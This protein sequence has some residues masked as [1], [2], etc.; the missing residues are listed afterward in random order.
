TVS[1]VGPDVTDLRPGDHVAYA[2]NAGAYGEYAVV[3]AWKLVKL[4]AGMDAKQGA[5]V[6]LEGMTAQYLAY[7]T[8]P[9]K[10]GQTALVHAGGGG[11]GLL[12]TQIARNIGATVIT[13]VGND[14]KAEL[15]RAAGAHHVIVYSR[16]DFDKEVR[17]ITGGKGVEVVYDSVGVNTFD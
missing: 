8:F 4:R 17:N 9:L 11:V 13:T 3:T 5:A 16:Q 14:E 1:A 2:M 7:S 10:A 6:M 12:L 15:S